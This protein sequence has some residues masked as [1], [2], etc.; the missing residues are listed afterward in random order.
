MQGFKTIII[1]HS[2]THK[3]KQVKDK[4]DWLDSFDIIEWP[5]LVH[6]HGSWVKYSINGIYHSGG[7]VTECD[8]L[9]SVKNVKLRT[10]SK[11]ELD[12]ININN[13]TTFYIKRDNLNYQSIFLFTERNKKTSHD[14]RLL[15][16]KFLDVKKYLYLNNKQLTWECGCNVTED[17]FFDVR[18]GIVNGKVCL[19]GYSVCMACKSSL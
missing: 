4:L 9:S 15:H 1:K 7:F 5:N 3:N 12:M 10:P 2:N 19:S 6:L 18:C 8:F 11:K 16:K 14:I 17:E 13:D